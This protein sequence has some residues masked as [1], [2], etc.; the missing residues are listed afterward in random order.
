M[1]PE[2]VVRD[3]YAAYGRRDVEAMMSLVSD[4][5]VEDLSGIGLVT[6][7][8]DEREFLSGL[9]AAFPDLVTEVTRVIAVG[10]LVA[11]E[12]HRSGTF[13]G[14]PW[15]GLPASG[16]PFV[17]RGGA[18]LVVSDNKITRI[19]GYY[20]TADFARQIGALPPEGSRA[21]R[22]GMALFRARV[23]VGRLL[24]RRSVRS[25]PAG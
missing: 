9:L 23:Q 4:D 14:T 16:K 17:L 6:G 3:F 1:T 11:V 2:Q 15:R 18:F 24:G 7:A 10:D 20:D 22:I 8:Q 19:T 5:I 13:S 12:W 25:H 21:E